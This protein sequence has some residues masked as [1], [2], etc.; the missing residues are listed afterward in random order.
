MYN[1]MKGQKE[2]W[3]LVLI[4]IYTKLACLLSKASKT[5]W[6]EETEFK[7]EKLT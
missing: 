6:N 1:K 3:N 2:D 4:C 7:K 5:I